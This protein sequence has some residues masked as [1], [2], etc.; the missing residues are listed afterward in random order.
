M[1][2]RPALYALALALALTQGC[3]RS[4]ETQSKPAFEPESCCVAA[5]LP[6]EAAKSEPVRGGTLR[7]RIN[8]EPAH[9][10][11][12][13]EPDWWLSR[14]V[15]HNVNESLVRPDPR[16]HPRYQMIPELAESWEESGDHLRFTFHLREGVR[17]HDGRPF[18][19]RDVKFTFDKLLDPAV[20]AGALRQGF[21]DLEAVE[22][23]DEKTIVLR[24]KRAYPWALRQLGSVP[25]YPSHA[26]EGLEGQAFNE[27]PY[28]RAPIGTGPYRF[29]SWERGSAITLARSDDY[30]GR[31]GHV[32]RMVFRVVEEENLAHLLLMRGEIDIDLALSPEQFLGAIR[33]PKLLA[34]YHRFAFFD[35]NFSWIG[36]NL[37]REPFTDPKLRRA[38]AMLF[39]RESVGRTLLGGIAL[40]ANCVFFHQGP[41][42]DPETHQPAFDPA[43]A[44]AALEAAGWRDTDG[45]GVR[46]KSGRPLRFAVLVPAGSALS[47][48]MMLAYQAGLRSAGVAMDVERV[49]WAVLTERLRERD[50]DACTL[51]WFGE[52]EEDPTQLWHSSQAAE[53]SNLVGYAS[54]RADELVEAIRAEADPEKRALLFRRLNAAIVE[55]APYLLLFHM[56]RRGLVHRRLRGL[57]ESPLESIQYRDLWIDPAYADR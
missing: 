42:C 4:P 39:D 10:G 6:T 35:A 19:S 22:A 56:P 49:E 40:P 55:D 48:Q 29:E 13:I 54:P 33:E 41:Q 5:K 30:W 17:W 21:A 50:F 3:K 20:R 37:R 52:L 18:T 53:G 36:W 15:L 12:L 46:D 32:D 28:M 31:P 27:A 47:E 26:F 45:D 9:L 1:C 7:V 38:L 24:W 11:Y 16:D 44:A 43:Q 14:I 25:I 8:T 2:R 34:R 57:Y 23:P 51:T